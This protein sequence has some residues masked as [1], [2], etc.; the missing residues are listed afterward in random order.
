MSFVRRRHL[1]LPFLLAAATAPLAAAHAADCAGGAA[2]AL[3][4]GQTARVE[5][6]PARAFSVELAAGQGLIVDLASLAALAAK[7]AADSDGEGEEGSAA[8][9]AP[10]PRD[11]LLC[12]AA[13]KVLAPQ[14]G[15][16]FEKGGSV[17]TTPDGQR[18]RFVAPAAG[19][20]TVWAAASGDAR[21]VLAR[22]RDLG[23]AGGVNAAKLGSELAGRVSSS[24][25]V[26]Y[27]FA[28]TAGQWVEIKSTSESDTVLHLAGPDR[29]GAYSE[30][31]SNDDSDGLNPKLRRRLPVTG[32]YYVQVDSLADGVDTFTLSLKTSVAP[33][34]PPAPV[35]LRAGTPVDAKLDGEKD[36]RLFTL[37]VVAGHNYRLELTAAYDGV[38]AIGLPNPVDTEDAKEGVEA[39]F[40]EVKSQDSGT[41]G[42]EKLEFTARSTA[43]L[44]VLVKSFGIG[45]TD[46]SYKLVATDLGN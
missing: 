25:P 1:A 36:V 7:P 37:P 10:P 22:N 8:A 42:T 2:G 19:R 4:I 13:G 39:G 18:L 11:L 28:G 6:G 31:A 45:E 30:I 15:E 46:G 23:K 41:T 43:Q 20:Y 32:T 40:S 33:P 27:S 38:V 34:A 3:A 17:S 14:P 29:A 44:L 5:P 12:D 21:E 24:A 9:K 16:V 26:T 35:A